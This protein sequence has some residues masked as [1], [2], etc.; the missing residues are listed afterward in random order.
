MLCS[1]N[2]QMY[3]VLILL[4]ISIHVGLRSQPSMDYLPKLLQSELNKA[5]GYNAILLECPLKNGKVPVNGKFFVVSNFQENFK[6]K[7]IYIGRVK[8]CRAGGCS[9]NNTASENNDSEYFDYFIL[10]NKN[11]AVELVRVYNYQ[12]T[13]GQE[14]TTKS[15]LKQFKN[16][17]GS[18]ELTVGKNVDAISGATISVNGLTADIE[19]KT[20]ILKQTILS[21]Q[22]GVEN[23]QVNK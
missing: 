6:V 19:H 14:V 5:N 4:F 11:G 2:Q 22:M 23:K 1:N 7:Y 17:D 18:T 8:S 16:Y 15:W 3:K 9:I 20:S 13:H 21:A 12:A 10:Y